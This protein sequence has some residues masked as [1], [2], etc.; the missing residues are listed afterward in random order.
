MMS[1]IIAAV[2]AVII[3][4]MYLCLFTVDQRQEAI[5]LRLGK[6]QTNSAGQAVVRKPGLHF[7]LPIITQVKKFDMRLR[8]LNITSSRIVTV[9]QKDVI[10]DAF[11]KWRINNIVTFYKATGGNERRADNLLSQKVRDGLRAE[12][13]KQTILELVSGERTNVMNILR[14][15]VDEVAKPL[16]IS[17]IDVRIKRIDLPTEVTTSVYER[18]RSNREKEA[19]LIRAQGTSAAEQ[20]SAKAD[21]DVTVILAEARS[22]AAKT[23]AAGEKEAATIY[24]S[25]YQSDPKFY[26]LYRSLESYDD[27]FAGEQHNTLVLQPRGMFFNYFNKAN[28]AT[29]KK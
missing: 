29:A 12:F 19:S 11:V 13:G 15:N 6:I 28:A 5:L 3:I 14:K 26:L 10:V 8:T 2:I 20:I 21:A 22:E 24:A 7:H 25:A 17:V 18:M 4:V 16:G 27:V 9:E 1:K 23:R